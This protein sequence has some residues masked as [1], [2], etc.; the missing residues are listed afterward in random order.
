MGYNDGGSGSDN[1]F[2]SHFWRHVCDWINKGFTHCLCGGRGSR[3]R[4]CCEESHEA[5]TLGDS[6]MIAAAVVSGG[7]NAVAGGIAGK[8]LT[9]IGADEIT[10]FVGGTAA[11][12]LGSDIVNAVVPGADAHSVNGTCH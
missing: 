5:Q 2:W 4:L 10:Q 7:I 3:L 11:G 8:A 12:I 9:A 1:D 6:P